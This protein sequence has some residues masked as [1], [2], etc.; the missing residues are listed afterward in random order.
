MVI[1]HISPSFVAANAIIAPIVRLSTVF[2]Q[3]L[4]Q[5]SSVMTGNALGAGS[6][7]KA[8]R[9]GVTFFTLSILIGLFAAVVIL[10]FTPFMIRYYNITDETRRIAHHLMFAVA[11]MVVFQSTQSVLTKG[12]LRGGGDTL[13]LMIADVAFLWVASVPLGALAGLYWHLEPFYIYIFLKIDWAIKT[14][15][16]AWRLKSRKWIRIV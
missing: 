3:G 5:A 4:G 12:V 1:G 7:E 16:C 2:T 8:Y 6:R 15:I 13:F 11:I 10:L 14:L 9:Q